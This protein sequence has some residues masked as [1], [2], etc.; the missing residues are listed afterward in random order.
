MDYN[1]RIMDYNLQIM[2]YNPWIMAKICGLCQKSAD[3]RGF[4]HKSSKTNL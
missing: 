3:F 4:W 2:D 1:L